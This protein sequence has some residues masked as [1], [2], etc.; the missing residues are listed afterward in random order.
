MEPA[1]LVAEELRRGSLAE[2]EL[3]EDL[4]QA[5]DRHCM[6]L[7]ALVGSLQASGKDRGA[8]S[9]LIDLMLRSYEEDLIQAL[10]KG[11]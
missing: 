1:Q 4:R 5:L 3:T 10:G 7:A 6:N 9:G 11:E 8:I 2:R